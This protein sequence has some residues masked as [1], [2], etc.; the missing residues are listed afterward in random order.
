MLSQTFTSSVQFYLFVAVFIMCILS[1]FMAFRRK[2]KGPGQI[3]PRRPEIG[4]PE[5]THKDLLGVAPVQ[6]K[7]SAVL[8]T[9]SGLNFPI[10]P[11]MPHLNDID[12]VSPYNPDFSGKEWASTALPDDPTRPPGRTASTTTIEDAQTAK[13][14][15]IPAQQK[16]PTPKMVPI[17]TMFPSPLNPNK[18]SKTERFSLNGD[19]NDPYNGYVNQPRLVGADYTIPIDAEMSKWTQFGPCSAQGIQ[20]RTRTCVHDEIGGGKP[21]STT[22]EQRSC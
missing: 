19:S 3:L 13:A 2:G 7:K 20:E 12:G 16:T 4:K 5:P 6:L 1:F 15:F 18:V 21:C 11:I 14:I 8:T 9:G 22:L 17:P 10:S